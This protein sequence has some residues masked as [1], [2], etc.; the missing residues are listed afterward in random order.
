M[1]RIDQCLCITPSL[2]STGGIRSADLTRHINK[3]I[4]AGGEAE[5]CSDG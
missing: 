4:V 3:A 2:G 1:T 5:V